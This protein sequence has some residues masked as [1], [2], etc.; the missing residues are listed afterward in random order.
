MWLVPLAMSLPILITTH[1]SAKECAAQPLPPPLPVRKPINIE[2]RKRIFAL[3]KP[4]A[5][6]DNIGTMSLMPALPTLRQ[7]SPAVEALPLSPLVKQPAAA[8][9]PMA[10]AEGM[11][12][13]ITTLVLPDNTGTLRRA[14]ARAI[15]RVLPPAV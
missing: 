6:P 5:R 11:Q 13:P 7:S 2:T 1:Q 14:G 12:L 4:L 8:A 15:V 9:G 3:L 10:L